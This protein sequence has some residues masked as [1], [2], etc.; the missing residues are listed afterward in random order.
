[1]PSDPKPSIARIS[2]HTSAAWAYN[3]LF[4][5]FT[6]SQRSI[7]TVVTNS[8]LARLDGGREGSGWF[9]TQPG[10][11]SLEPPLPF[12]PPLSL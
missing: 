9:Q 4:D 6:E 7:I 11:L 8:L 5:E 3:C 10:W 1:M 12:R 2:M